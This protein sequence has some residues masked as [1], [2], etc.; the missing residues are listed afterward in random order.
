MPKLDCIPDQGNLHVW[1]G[2]Q[3]S[4]FLKFPW[5]F[6]VQ[7]PMGSTSLWVFSLYFHAAVSLILICLAVPGLSCSTRDLHSLL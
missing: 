7:T 6:H 4:E 5:G 2:T 3:T 1:E